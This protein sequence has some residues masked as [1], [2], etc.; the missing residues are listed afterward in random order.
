MNKK[1]QFYDKR[2]VDLNQKHS[3]LK[4]YVRL[5]NRVTNV[6]DIPNYFNRSN[7]SSNFVIY[8]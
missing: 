8:W 7:E 4:T 5:N 2:R 6:N 1:N 3:F